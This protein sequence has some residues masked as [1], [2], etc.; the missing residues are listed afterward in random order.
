MPW[1]LP[2]H[3]LVIEIMNSTKLHFSTYGSGEPIMILHGF[4]GM[5]D[6]WKTFARMLSEDYMIITPDLRNHGRS[7]HSE[8]HSYEAMAEDIEDFIEENDLQGLHLMGHS[9]GGKVAMQVALNAEELLSSL[10]VVDITPARYKGGH[11]LIIQTMEELPLEKYER[12][13]D[14]ESFMSER[15]DDISV[16][17]FLMKNLKRN[18]EA[19]GFKWKFNLES[20]SR[21]YD[22]VLAEITSDHTF[23]KPTAFIK[24]ERSNY[25]REEY[26]EEIYDLFPA[27]E[28]YE[29]SGAGHW[30]HADKPLDLLGYVLNHIDKSK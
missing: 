8:V 30:V 16:I 22:N 19:K 7:P 23:S 27:A 11:E 4:F 21:N 12:R 24:G 2:W 13:S 26:K 9:M 17:Q 15:L 1:Q 10:I 25:I 3:F 14:V 29:V 6:N 18:K 28:L 20:L 5:S